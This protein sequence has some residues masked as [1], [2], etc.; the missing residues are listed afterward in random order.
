MISLSSELL[1]N[2]LFDAYNIKV[3]AA[4]ETLAFLATLSQNRMK[5]SPPSSI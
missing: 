4:E 5:I 3:N 2:C 1:Q